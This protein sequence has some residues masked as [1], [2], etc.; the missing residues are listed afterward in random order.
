[1]PE[2]RISWK[3]SNLAL[4]GSDLDH[5]IKEAAANGEPQWDGIGEAPGT[6]IWRIEQFRVVA[7]PEEKNGTF[8]K[9]DSYIVLNT[10]E[11]ND[12]LLHDVHIWIGSESSQDEYGTAAYK[13]VECDEKL[14][15]APVQHREV[16]GKESHIFKTY[17]DS[18]T[19]LEGGVDTGFNHVEPT[20]AEPH[21]YRVKGTEKKMSLTQM[22]LSK[23]SLN[24]GD[25]FVVF[26]GPE[27]VWLWNGANANPDEQAK[28]NA[29][30]ES[31]CTEG[32]VTVLDQGEGDDS[33]ADFWSYLG[34]GEI[35]EAGEDDSDVAEFAPVLYKLHS[36]GSTEKVGEGEKVKIGFAPA[37]IKMDKDLLDQADVFLLDAGWELFCWMGSSASRDEKLA[38]I[39]NADKYAKDNDKMYLP[40]SIIKSG[41]EPHDFN[42]YF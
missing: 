26:A 25:S 30:A 7:W 13:M 5:K 16:Q 29:H 18:L 37:T 3:D 24:G 34:D 40:L 21:L 9:G 20:V 38:A 4:V 1:M 32:T 19:Y 22:P 41:Y 36:D 11:R 31:M 33:D 6:R 27:K 23:S 10:Y 42:N 8:H 28:A 14:G 2:E 35:Q 17:F 15:G 12:K 39:S